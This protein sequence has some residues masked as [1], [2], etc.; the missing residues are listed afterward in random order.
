MYGCVEI[1]DPTVDVDKG[2]YLLYNG[3]NT[4]MQVLWQARGLDGDTVMW[5]TDPACS[6]GK[7]LCPRCDSSHLHKFTIKD[8]VPGTKYYYQV[9]IDGNAYTGTFRTAPMEDQSVVKFFVMGDMRTDVV[10]HNRVATQINA[11][12]AVDP[13]SQTVM[14]SVGDLVT[15]GDYETY[16]AEEF[17][18]PI[19]P[20]IKELHANLPFMSARGNHESSGKLFARY[21]PYHFTGNYYYSFDYGPV[22]F[23]MIDQY[24]PYT[25][26]TEQYTWIV[27][28][29][30]GSDKK[31]KMVCLHEPGWSAGGGHANNLSVQQYLEPLFEQ[32]HVAV[33]FAGHNHY[34][35]RAFV[36]GTGGASVV[37]ITTGGGGAPLHSPNPDSTNVVAVSK[38]YQFCKVSIL[39]EH[40]LQCWAIS[41]KGDTLDEFQVQ[42]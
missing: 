12:W 39:D 41:D 40:Q 33:V 8:L 35:A 5:G 17:F 24:A 38:N 3:D 32:Y 1:Q 28:D 25:P 19:A 36:Q 16:W 42:Q 20:S 2:P 7:M 11:S 13:E 10:A 29:L 26:G 31:W 4:Q 37:H 18:S 22:H 15:D 14:L 6:L 23:T 27:A 34:Y 21:L 30:A 9:I